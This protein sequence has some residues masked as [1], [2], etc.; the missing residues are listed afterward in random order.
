M[1]HA[2]LHIHVGTKPARVIAEKIIS[3]N[4]RGSSFELPLKPV[5]VPVMSSSWPQ[6]V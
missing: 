4:E 3:T 5:C 2:L 6:K 1:A